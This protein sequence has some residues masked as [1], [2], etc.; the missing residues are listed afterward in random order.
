M[1]FYRTSAAD[2]SLHPRR[3]INVHSRSATPGARETGSSFADVSP[4][5][6]LYRFFAIRN[7]DVA[8]VPTLMFISDVPPTLAPIGPRLAR[9]L[10]AADVNSRLET[11]CEFET[12]GRRFNFFYIYFLRWN[13]TS[14]PIDLENLSRRE[15]LKLFGRYFFIYLKI[16]I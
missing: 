3:P 9:H 16:N 12:F 7:H 14:P 4:P 2:R 1:F 6:P 5:V 11:A 8:I 13:L 10:P 15:D